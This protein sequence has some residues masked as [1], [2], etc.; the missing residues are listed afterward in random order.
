M[1]TTFSLRLV[2]IA[3]HPSYPRNSENASP[4][5]TLTAYLSSAD[6]TKPPNTASHTVAIPIVSVLLRFITVPPLS[7]C[8]RRRRLVTTP[9]DHHI[10][11]HERG[12]IGRRCRSTPP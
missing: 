2:E 7:R 9:A 10:S 8:G 5:G 4:P 3:C 11:S 1:A 12:S 6:M